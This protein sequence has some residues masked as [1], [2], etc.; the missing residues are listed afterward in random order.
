M[1]ARFT[2]STSGPANK[3]ADAVITFDDE[4]AAGCEFH[5]Y[6][7]WKTKEGEVF[8]SPPSREFES[9]G[10]KR[11]F[12]LVRA[13]ADDDKDAVKAFKERILEAWKAQ[14]D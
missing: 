12:N 13:A 7:V 5:G 11:R 3:L 6:A 1:Q 4:A 14:A 9:N 10:E 2:K 8:V